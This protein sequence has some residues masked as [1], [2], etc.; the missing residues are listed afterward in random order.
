MVDADK[1]VASKRNRQKI[2]ESSNQRYEN[3]GGFSR[4]FGLYIGQDIH[5]ARS[6]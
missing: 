3:I 1:G 2:L 5:E 6:S 4:E